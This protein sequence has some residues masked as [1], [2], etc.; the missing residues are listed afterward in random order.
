MKTQIANVTKI[1]STKRLTRIAS[2]AALFVLLCCASG[3]WAQGNHSPFAYR[4]SGGQTAGFT[5][6]ST[7]RCVIEHVTVFGAEEG[8]ILVELNTS[9]NGSQVNTTFLYT[10]TNIPGWVNAGAATYSDKIFV[11]PNGTLGINFQNGPGYTFVVPPNMYVSAFGY[12]EPK[13]T[14]DDF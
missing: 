9:S 7:S 2:L 1:A 12:Y 8:P 3:A 4:W 5:C 13:N 10:E 11:D 6:P 14:T